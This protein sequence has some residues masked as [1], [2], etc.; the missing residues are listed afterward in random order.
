MNTEEIQESLLPSMESDFSAGAG[1]V[2]AVARAL[3]ILN[4]FSPSRPELTLTQITQQLHCPTSTLL[5]QLRT[6]EGAGFLY[7]VKGSTSYR[8]GYKLMERSYCVHASTPIIQYA[9]PVMEELESQTDSFIYLT[10][11]LNG[12]VFYLESVC[13]G[14]R[15]VRYSIAGKTLPL[16]CTGQYHQHRYYYIMYLSHCSMIFLTLS[17]HASHALASRSVPTTCMACS[18]NAAPHCRLCSR[19]PP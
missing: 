3:E 6:L 19:L 4:C 11:H 9:L 10:T 12:L 5:N 7:R 2:N 13:P 14:Q 1:K 18:P 16:H 15:R 8:L 17:R